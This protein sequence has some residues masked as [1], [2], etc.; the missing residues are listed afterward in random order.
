MTC[1]SLIGICANSSNF[2][3]DVSQF[4]LVSVRSL[5]G[6]IAIWGASPSSNSGIWKIITNHEHVIILVDAIVLLIIG[7]HGGHSSPPAISNEVVSISRYVF[8]IL[9]TDIANN[10]IIEGGAADAGFSWGCGFWGL[11][12]GWCLLVVGCCL[13][14]PMELRFSNKKSSPW[15]FLCFLF[16]RNDLIQFAVDHWDVFDQWMMQ[17]DKHSEGLC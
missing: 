16:K 9:F 7:N 13:V 6:C 1:W 5:Q 2:P 11:D 17:Q 14:K 12:L 3:G 4:S 8:G 10:Y 15:R